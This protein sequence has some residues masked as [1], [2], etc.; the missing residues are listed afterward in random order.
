MILVSVD[1]PALLSP[2]SASTDLEAD[3]ALGLDGTVVPGKLLDAQDRTVMGPGR[4]W[5]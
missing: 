2:S 1:F 4:R 5:R 3:A